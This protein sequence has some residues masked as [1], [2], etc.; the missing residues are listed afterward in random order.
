[1]RV[2]TQMI[3][4]AVH[5]DNNPV[6]Y[7][8]LCMGDWNNLPKGQVVHY[9]DP[10][11]QGDCTAK[12]HNP[13]KGKFR[14]NFDFDDLPRI[15]GD[16][17][18]DGSSTSDSDEAGGMHTGQDVLE[19]FIERAIMRRENPRAKSWHK[20]LGKY[21]ELMQFENTRSDAVHQLLLA[22]IKSCALLLDLPNIRRF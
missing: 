22:W 17:Q 8:V 5:A 4:G 7:V 20:T 11:K 15:D 3:E 14:N 16:A 18:D 6:G 19:H 1:M 12:S 9:V 2:Q 13:V 10:L 21:V